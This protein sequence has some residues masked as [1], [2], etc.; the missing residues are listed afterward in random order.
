MNR[1]RRRRAWPHDLRVLRLALLAGAPAVLA[2]LVLLWTTPHAPKTRWT[3]ALF[4]VGAW[5]G[6]ALAARERVTRPLQT[7]SNMLA[8]LREG[9]F[10][11][12]ARH[13]SRDDALGLV[14]YEA[15]ILSETLREQRLSALEA[16][17]LLQRVMEEIDV[18]TFAFDA[19]QRL[20]LVNRTG[21]R[22]LQ[23]PVEYLLGRDAR[24]LGLGEALSGQAPRVVDLAFPSGAGRWEVRHS[25]FRQGGRPHRLLVL[26]DLS[27]TLR[28]EE[29]QAWQR[30]VRVL[31]HEINNSLAPVKS[32]AES[33]NSML[34]RSPRPP[35]LD[36]DLTAG[37]SIIGTRA[38]SLGR[39]MSSY[40]RLAR[41]PR[42]KLAPLDVGTWVRRVA[43]LETRVPVEVVAGP[44]L[45]IEADS[46]Q[47]EQLLIN[48][49]RNAADAALES[50]GGVRA[51]WRRDNGR[52]DVW[53]E[54]DG[55][56]LA[57]TENLFVPFFTTKPSGSGVGL[58]LSRQIA[59]GHGGTVTLE[60]R[61]NARGCVARLRIPISA[62][63]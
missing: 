25:E 52:L 35:R 15:N 7:L 60:N 12:R 9:D 46:D 26:A 13:A 45:T 8:A 20:R 63:A 55:P 50:G 23:R 21:E 28:E 24:E 27:R 39:F 29:R 43:G 59:E 4:A 37:L 58:A 5:V 32:I 38:E 54:D 57:S 48:L 56:G 44:D 10:S 2:T 49:V 22:L 19:E 62:T 14:L 51:G 31:S 41:L 6:F 16:T 36:E 47:L 1:P 61:R 33:L 34:A 17:A 53:V 11:I 40:A 3:V 42:P 18:A 30:L